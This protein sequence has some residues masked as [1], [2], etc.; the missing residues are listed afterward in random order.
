MTASAEARLPGEGAGAPLGPQW[1]EAAARAQE[2][3]LATGATVVSCTAPLG[4]GGLG[5]HMGEILD[6][7][8]R[9]G[10]PGSCISGSAREGS[11]PR[12][13]LGLPYLASVLRA[14]PALPSSPGVRARAAMIEFD[15]FAAARLP[16]AQ[17]LIAFNGQALAQFA[18]ARRAGFASVSLVSANPHL[19]RLSRQHALAHRRYPLEGS[20][21][22]RLLDRNLAEYARA[23]RIYF[24]SEYVRESFLEQGIR[25]ELLVRFPLTPDPR[26]RPEAGRAPAERFEIVY[27]GSL[28]V[29]KGVPLLIDAV[30]RLPE[31]DIGLRLVGGWGTPG[32]RR[33]VERAR[34]ADRRITVCPGDPLD[35]LRAAS[36]CV[37]PAYEDG[38][39]YAPA[40]ALA[41][42]V[43]VI[44]SEDTGMKEL[45]DRGRDGLV[46]PTGDLDALTEAIEA[47]CRGEILAR[48]APGG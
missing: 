41:A 47:A 3:A 15:D 19:R 13:A 48:P 2:A 26:Y 34:A 21:A 24:A 17:N 42:G 38:F 28:A 27:V 16:A 32:M 25:D 23:D 43:P 22:T 8:A 33:F 10:S 29:H 37:H 30:R 20:W 12:H 11:P 9:A 44:V 14:M 46:L 4:S 31:L 18:A 5:R 45:L 35:H 1:R 36:L 6:A 7:L 40:E 39:A